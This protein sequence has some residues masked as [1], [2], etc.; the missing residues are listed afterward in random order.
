MDRRQFLRTSAVGAAGF[1]MPG[2]LLAAAGPDVAVVKGQPGAA[3]RAAVGLLGGMAAFVK[4]G[5]RVVI[6]PNMSFASPAEAGANT[7]PLVVQALAALCWE[8][9]AASVLILDNTLAPSRL[10][11]E[12]S[13][14]PEA[15]AAVRPGMVF[16]MDDAGLYRE[17]SIPGGRSLA[18]SAV[19]RE[20]L[21][22]DV[23]IAAP[24]AKSHSGTGVSLSLK[25]MMGLI[26]DRGVM[27]GRGLDAC[28]VDLCM[29]LKAHLTVIDATHVLSTGGPRGPG[30]VLDGQT[31]IASTDM[32]A[33]D[34]YTVSAFPWY[35]QR[36]QPGQVGHIRLAHERGLGRMDVENLRVERLAL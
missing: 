10:C 25:G 23:L 19:A 36:F 20:A 21:R 27:H 22:A 14:I 6:K 13:G 1:L 31:V 9:G 11:L 5:H 17:V 29:L 18:R 24:T 35:G 7:H 8:S 33:A 34:A 4:P 15:A 26:A 32:V 12:A 3:T 16:A 28:I 30:R 2:G